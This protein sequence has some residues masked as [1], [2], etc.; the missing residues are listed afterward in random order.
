MTI[1]DNKRKDGRQDVPAFSFVIVVVIGFGAG[2]LGSNP[3]RIR[4]R[5]LGRIVNTFTGTEDLVELDTIPDH[6]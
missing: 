6:D 3:F 5:L 4:D 1:D 2:G